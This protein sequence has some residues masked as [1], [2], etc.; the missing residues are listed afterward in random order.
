MK[1][2]EKYYYKC[3]VYYP[4]HTRLIDEIF[5]R[6]KNQDEAITYCK[7]LNLH[8]EPLFITAEKINIYEI[9]NN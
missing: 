7:S 5:I 8:S 9:H 2:S 3:I 6:A 4:I 1:N